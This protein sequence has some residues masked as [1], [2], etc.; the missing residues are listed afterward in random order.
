M[1]GA[2]VT[3]GRSI[4]ESEQ[5]RNQEDDV[6]GAEVTEDRSIDE[7]VQPRNQEDDVK[8]AE[9]TEEF[10]EDHKVEA[11]HETDKNEL[12][13][14]ERHTSDVKQTERP[15]P[16]PRRFSRECRPSAKS[17]EY[18]MYQMV[19]RPDYKPWITS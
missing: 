6:K 11:G 13:E 12:V 19:N 8:A 7:S 5:P 2:E 4:D 10:L 15:V 16:T 18:V 17:D 14:E 9:M 1:K 3:E